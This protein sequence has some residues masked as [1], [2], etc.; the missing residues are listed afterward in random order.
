[1]TPKQNMQK[2]IRTIYVSDVHLST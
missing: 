1:M 2:I